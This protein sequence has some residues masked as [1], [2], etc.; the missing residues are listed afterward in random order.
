MRATRLHVLEQLV[1]SA[2][3]GDEERRTHHRLDLLGRLGI[4]VVESPLGDILQVDDPHDV[5]LVVPDDGD[6]TEPTAQ[7]ERQRLPQC[8]VAFDEHHVGARHHHF[9][10]KCLTELED[11]VD[12]LALVILDQ[13]TLLRQVDEVT[14]LR[15]TCERPV[16]ETLARG[17]R[18]SK[19]NEHLGQR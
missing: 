19:Q 4:T 11:R 9:A 7:A 15:L 8:L 12:H 13:R 3:V 6:P 5:V 16:P 14:Q 1:G 17:Q 18:I 2:T 10:G